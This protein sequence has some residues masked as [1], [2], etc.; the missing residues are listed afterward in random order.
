MKHPGV[1][2]L[3]LLALLGGCFSP[4]ADTAT[5]LPPPSRPART[6]PSGSP[7][8]PVPAAGFTALAT[9]QQVVGSIAVGRPD[10]FAPL[11]ASGAAAGDPAV[12]PVAPLPEGFRFSGVIGS[13]GQVQ[14]LVE[15]GGQSGPLCVGPRG[16]CRGSGTAALLPAG[17][18]VSAI[19]P[20]QGRLILRQ[21][22]QQ[23]LLRLDQ[24]P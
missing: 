24:T 9:P 19:D 8:Q 3:P 16:A 20:V 4:D 14:A 22:R 18:S 13:G 23:R 17:W 2:V 5:S 7:T 10:P 1:L 12:A 11:A 15:V 21:G 6:A